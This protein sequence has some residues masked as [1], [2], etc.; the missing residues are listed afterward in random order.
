MLHTG[1]ISKALAYHLFL[2]TCNIRGNTGSKTVI[3]V[4]LARKTQALLLHIKRCGL[5]YLVFTLLNISDTSLFLQLRE[6]ILH[7]LYII[8]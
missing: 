7:R 5:L 2:D 4:M 8:F 1:E 6:W 3:Y